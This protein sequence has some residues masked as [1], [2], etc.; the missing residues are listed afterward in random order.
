M[1]FIAHKRLKS[2]NI[3]TVNENGVRVTVLPNCDALMTVLFRQVLTTMDMNINNCDN[4][5]IATL[6]VDLPNFSAL[7]TLNLGYT[8][9]NDTGV[10]KLACVLPNY[11]ALET[12]QLNNN[13][14]GNKGAISLAAVLPNLSALTTLDFDGNEIGNEGVKSLADAL[15]NCV[16][17]TTL[18]L[19]NNKIGNKGAI[20][21]AAVLP[22][23]VSLTT[24]CLG[25][26]QIGNEGAMSLAAALPSSPF[27]SYLNVYWNYDIDAAMSYKIYSLVRLQPQH[28]AR[29]ALVT[30]NRK[31]HMIFGVFVNRVFAA[32]LLGF[33]R[34][35]C[36]DNSAVP[37]ADPEMVEETLE[38]FHRF[39]EKV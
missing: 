34:V 39:D 27:L 21:L 2:D 24:L 22:N 12:L 9:I 3:L 18:L 33:I 25:W 29:A 19:R 28:K 32:F 11:R 35:V 15:T 31:R 20:S 30:W 5:G 13:Q 6:T 7:T 8:Q 17:L 4:D 23:C 10:A 26:N 1:N 14:I 36:T 37:D 38:S 16:S